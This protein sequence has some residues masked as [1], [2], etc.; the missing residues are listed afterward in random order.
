MTPF[1]VKDAFGAN[2]ATWIANA[3][4]IKVKGEQTSFLPP[5]VGHVENDV[6]MTLDDIGNLNTRSQVLTDEGG[7]RINFANTSTFASIGSLTWTN[8]STAVT[9][10][11]ILLL[12]VS[13]GDYVRLDSNGVQYLVMHITD[14]E[15]TIATPYA[16]TNSTGASSRSKVMTNIVG[17]STL[18]ITNGQALFTSGVNP[19][20][21]SYFTRLLDLPSMVNNFQLTLS[22]RIANASFYI[23]FSDNPDP[24]MAK[25]YAWLL[26]DGTTATTTKLQSAR[27]P[28]VVPTGGEIQ[29]S[30]ITIS[31]TAS[32]TEFRIE[33]LRDRAM[34]FQNDSLKGTNKVSLPS[35]SDELYLTVAWVNGAT[36]PATTTTATIDFIQVANNNELAVSNI[37]R[38]AQP[39]R[40][41]DG[42]NFTP[43]G[44]AAARRTYTQ[45]T[46][47]TNSASVLATILALKTDLSSVAGTAT[48]NG[49]VA[50][51]M[52]IGGSAAHSSAASG[53]PVQVGGVVS[54][55]LDTSLVASDAARM[56]MTTAQQLVIKPYG[57]AENDWQF[58]GVLTTTTAVAAK[59]LGAAGI[60]NYVTDISFQNTSATATTV[61]L[62][63]GVTTIAQW[64]APASMAAPVSI[65][66]NTPRKGTAATAMNVNCGTAAANVLINVGGYQS[67]QSTITCDD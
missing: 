40:I 39:V 65:L 10:T 38:E 42:T 54:T 3:L 6:T 12:D 45:L 60:R 55:A 58:T 30:N 46:D 25:V 18:T 63:D 47:G 31:T 22:Q 56:L 36:P 7:F 64:N 17:D 24:T 49:G 13:Y 62:Q 15:I 5:Y 34:A 37:S 2:V 21:V 19:S 44:D 57:T 61:L 35:P 26:F 27:N 33:L 51:L 67:F 59:A 32:A 41:T 16:G 50:G 66:F 43:T 14:T 52:G 4:G 8:G 1:T 29:S 20:Q 9:G 23:G 53:N 28:I 48:L 11:G